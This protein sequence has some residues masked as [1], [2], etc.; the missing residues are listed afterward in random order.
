MIL[1]RILNEFTWTPYGIVC[2]DVAT[3]RVVHKFMRE[4]IL[5]RHLYVNKVIGFSFKNAQERKYTGTYIARHTQLGES[6]PELMC[7]LQD[8]I[9]INSKESSFLCVLKTG[10]NNISD[11]M[12]ANDGDANRQAHFLCTND[13]VCRVLDGSPILQLATQYDCGYL[14]MRNNSKKL[15][16]EYFPC[17]TDFS[18]G[19]FFRVLPLAVNTTLIPIR[20]Y[21]DGTPEILK[22]LLQQYCDTV[23]SGALRKDDKAWIQMFG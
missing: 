22:S 18:A 13:E 5:D 23:K 17:C 6:Y 4:L 7:K 10:V 16:N 20:F 19:D 8:K 11:M 9:I 21:Y 14:H 3:T 2:P 1:D 15:S 12:I